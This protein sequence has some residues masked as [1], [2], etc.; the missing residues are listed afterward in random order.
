ME[1]VKPA[2]LK[3]EIKEV[4]G[5]G[6]LQPSFEVRINERRD[7][8][9][10]KA[11]VL[12]EGSDILPS[13]IVHL[14]ALNGEKSL[15]ST[16]TTL[17]AIL[18]DK[19]QLKPEKWLKLKTE[20]FQNFRVKVV[21]SYSPGDLP[22][23]DKETPKPS[24]PSTSKSE[25]IVEC[26]YLSKL[27][28]QGAVSTE[29]LDE[30][31]KSRNV[32]D[33]STIKLSFEPD[34]LS[35][36]NSEQVNLDLLS[37]QS[38]KSF[39]GSQMK[40]LVRELCEDVRQ[41][42]VI[43]KALPE[44][45]DSFQGKAA[46][47]KRIGEEGRE[48]IGRMK[49]DWNETKLKILEK[50]EVRDEA[51]NRL[52][53]AQE[54]SKELEKE[55]DEL[56]SSLFSLQK[57]GNFQDIQ[58]LYSKLIE[59]SEIQKKEL[60]EKIALEAVEMKNSCEK[61]NQEINTFKRDSED[62]Q[63]RVKEVTE[64]YNSAK[65]SNARLRQKV[66][67][68]KSTLESPEIVQ[69]REESQLSHLKSEINHR[70]KLTNDIKSS[71]LSIKQSSSDLSYQSSNL[72]RSKTQNNSD[73]ASLKASIHST[74]SSI[75]QIEKA[76]LTSVLSKVSNEQI[77]CLRADL[78]CLISDISSLKDFYSKSH[79]PVLLDLD[80][81]A[82]IISVESEKIL[83]RAEKLDQMIESIDQKE[84]ELESLKDTMGQVKK[85]HIVH[86]AVK[87]DPVD[88]TLA[89]IVNSKEIPVKFTR[90]DGGNYLFGSTKVYLKLENSKLLA[91]IKGGFISIEDFL[92]TY[93]P[94]EQSRSEVKA[95][96]SSSAKSAVSPSR[97]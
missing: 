88:Q 50:V 7:L 3:L 67:D 55:R 13:S 40:Q 11:S 49:N 42:E 32:N 26:P 81:G 9:N 35:I 79:R 2:K 27:G 58:I 16:K 21:A 10:L 4:T 14:T 89:D 80:K 97:S 73:L 61:T 82:E 83:I 60:Q 72:L 1:S 36:E 76:F 5:C 95:K 37:V 15:G 91:K 71:I 39:S 63:K 47:R 29:A 66:N 23:K 19:L 25:K 74:Q 69:S 84:E 46:D 59:S 75:S 34:N 96:S 54:T 43:S 94:I 31:W 22:A 24:R 86:T 38:I 45:R 53:K 78:S 41:L 12:I 70:D 44:L 56:R 87:G 57:T 93:L 17:T 68:L 64:E 30:L 65:D 6:K 85:R 92:S 28:S 18:T 8:L 48:L 52:I 77:C 90:L 62:L 51:K 33:Q 20:E